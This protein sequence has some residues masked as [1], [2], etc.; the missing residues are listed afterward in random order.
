MA[1]Q[2]TLDEM[3]DCL[4]AMNHPTARTCQA[5]VE[6]I[7][8]VMADTIATTLGVT[9]GAATFEGTV[10]LYFIVRRQNMHFQ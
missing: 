8:T 7:G 9:A 4:I 10:A 5:V 3:L 2:L 1:K 6:A